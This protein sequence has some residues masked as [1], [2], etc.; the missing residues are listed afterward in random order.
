MEGLGDP[1]GEDP[2]VVG[3]VV[4]SQGVAVQQHPGESLAPV[5]VMC[6]LGRFMVIMV[7]CVSDDG[8]LQAY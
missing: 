5:Y 1:S 2:G 4:A 8:L 7:R 3:E 6:M